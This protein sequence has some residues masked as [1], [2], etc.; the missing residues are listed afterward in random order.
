MLTATDVRQIFHRDNMPL[1]LFNEYFMFTSSRWLENTTIYIYIYIHNIERINHDRN[2][3]LYGRQNTASIPH[4]RSLYSRLS[5][6]MP[7]PP[8]CRPTC[9]VTAKSTQQPFHYR[10]AVLYVHNIASSPASAIPYTLPR[11]RGS[12][13]DFDVIPTLAAVCL[14]TATPPP[15]TAL[16]RQWR[17]R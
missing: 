13:T 8:A 2:Q 10:R 15:S 11:M 4:T 5:A 14:R 16:L 3:R 1:T 12:S 7:C 9:P 6:C 17:L